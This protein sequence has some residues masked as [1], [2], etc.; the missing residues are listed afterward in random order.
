[1]ALIGRWVL[2]PECLH[3]SGKSIYKPV[4]L[5]GQWVLAP[6][7]LHQS[8]RALQARGVDWLRARGVD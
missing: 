4:A 5:I 6:V 1:M 3:Q 8:G 7:F 2:A